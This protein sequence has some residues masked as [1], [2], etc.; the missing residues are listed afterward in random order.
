M[1]EYF[2]WQ[3]CSYIIPLSEVIFDNQIDIAIL[4]ET[5]LHANIPDSLAIV[6][7]YD[8]YRKDRADVDG[9]S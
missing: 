9:M 7:G 6:T 4:V 3:S 2:Q 5:W 1:C 8:V